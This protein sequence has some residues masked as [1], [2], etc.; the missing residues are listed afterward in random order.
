MKHLLNACGLAAIGV[1]VPSMLGGSDFRKEHPD[2]AC[3][4]DLD[5]WDAY[6][7]RHPDVFSQMLQVWCRPI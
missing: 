2:P 3:W 6:E 5:L 1:N 4:A 7:V